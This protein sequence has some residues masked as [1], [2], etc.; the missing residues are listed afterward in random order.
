MVKY[1]EVV[2]YNGEKYLFIQLDKPLINGI[3]YNRF[4]LRRYINDATSILMDGLRPSPT[5]PYIIK[6]KYITGALNKD[7]DDYVLLLTEKGLLP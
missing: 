3:D 4:L 2:I 6:P 1:Y 5:G 7:F